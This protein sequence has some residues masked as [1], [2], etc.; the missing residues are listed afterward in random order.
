MQLTGKL[1]DVDK[2]E[3]K[4]E[5]IE[6]IARVLIGTIGA[7]GTGTDGLQYASHTA[8]FIDRDWSPEIMK[9]CEDRLNRRGQKYKVNIYVL[10]CEKS[11]VT[12]G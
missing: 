8:I 10:E 7:M 3:N 4:K 12:R 1:K 5:F 2:E 6:G 9:Q 11:F